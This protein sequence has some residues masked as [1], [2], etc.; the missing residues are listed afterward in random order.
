VGLGR[1]RFVAETVALAERIIGAANSP[2]TPSS[3]KDGA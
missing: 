2:T 3:R 1:R